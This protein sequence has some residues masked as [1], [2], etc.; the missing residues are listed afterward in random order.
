MS[1]TC[2]SG[3][4]AYTLLCYP[5]RT[6]NPLGSDKGMWGL[7]EINPLGS[8]TDQTNQTKHCNKKKTYF[9]HFIHN[10][11]LNIYFGVITLYIKPIPLNNSPPHWHLPTFYGKK[12]DVMNTNQW[13][14]NNATCIS[15]F[16]HYASDGAGTNVYHHKFNQLSKE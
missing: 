1:V 12:N 9:I 3:L 14:S 15:I 4:R 5:Q 13:K 16:R 6:S 2:Q 8:S 7:S 11:F 10:N